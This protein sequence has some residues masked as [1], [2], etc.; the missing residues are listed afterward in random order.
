M[1]EKAVTIKYK[2]FESWTELN[3]ADQKLMQKAVE[4]AEDAYAPY[5]NFRVGAAVQLENEMIEIGSN[6]ENAAYPSGLCAERVTLFS[7]SAKNPT[8]LMKT[9][10]IYAAD[11]QD[12]ES[13]IS[14]CGSCR[15][16]MQEYEAKQNKAI[17]VLVMNKAKRVFEFES[18]EDLLPLAFQISFPKKQ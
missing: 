3:P 18:C 14:P 1:K 13:Q 16:V 2:D 15:Q 5:S 17:R 4:A 6:Q 9:L 12:A 11:A 8:V 10:A 7:A